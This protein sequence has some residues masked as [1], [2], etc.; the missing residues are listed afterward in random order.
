MNK[1]VNVNL[2]GIVF[3]IDETAYETLRRYLEGLKTHFA[4]TLGASEIIQDIEARVAELLQH[5]DS[6][7]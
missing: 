3:S 1:V 5:C 6:I 4:G 2:N 7:G